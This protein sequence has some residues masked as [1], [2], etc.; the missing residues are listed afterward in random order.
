MHFTY[1]SVKRLFLSAMHK[2]QIPMLHRVGLTPARFDILYMLHER[3]EETNGLTRQDD[4]WKALGLSRA[5]ICKMMK[6]LEGL[7]FLTRSRSTRKRI[8]VSLTKLGRA[9]MRHAL[10]ILR[11][12]R[13]GPVERTTHSIFVKKWWSAPACL[14]ELETFQLYIDGFLRKLS[15][16][17]THYYAWHPDD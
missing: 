2:V 14:Q 13:R 9:I 1:F 5:T 4:I 8:Y 6:L 12:R 10:K 11:L 7:G 3:P 15:D 16:T 17:A